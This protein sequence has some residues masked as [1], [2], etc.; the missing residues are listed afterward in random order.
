MKNAGFIMIILLLLNVQCIRKE[1]EASAENS[2]YPSRENIVDGVRT[3]MN[4]EFPRDGRI[5]YQMGDVIT[6]GEEGGPEEE[7]L[8]FP[9]DIR[10]GPQGNIYVFDAEDYTIKVYDDKSNWIRNIGRRGQGPGEYMN[11]TDFDI[12]LDG[13]I[14]ICDIRQRR[15][16]ILN[17][18][19]TFNS[20]F[21]MKGPCNRLELDEAGQLY[22]PQYIPFKVTGT[23]GSKVWEMILMRTDSKGKKFFKYGKYPSLKF[24]WRL[25]KTEQ[26]VWV[27]SP[28][29]SMDGYTTVWTVDKEG[30]L[31]LGY[32]RDYLI[33]VLDKKGKPLFRFGREFTPIKHPL[34]SPDLAHPEYYPAYYSR[35]LFFDDKGNLWLKQYTKS[36]EAGHLYDVFSPEGIF[37]QQAEVPEKIIRY[38]NGKV[39]TIVE[40]A[41][42][43]YVARFYKLIKGT[44]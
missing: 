11:M 40:A 7:I 37:I 2:E 1:K 41:S 16:S 15:I 22:I 3:V 17:S 34:Y 44:P 35:Y 25:R 33:S 43:N 12:S 38:Q 14:F 27:G 36:N 13:R 18:D 6:L 31:Y 39:Y 20:S 42:G 21:I 23:S 5:R 9:Y 24:V 10:V 28:H 4:P 19:G 8:F 30:R 29:T 26:G 32:S